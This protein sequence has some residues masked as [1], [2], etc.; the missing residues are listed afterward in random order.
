MR[1]SD[2]PI[3]V[4]DSGIGGLSVLKEA[5]NILTDEKFIYFGDTARI[6]YGIRT[7]EEIEKFTEESFEFLK[8]QGVK[9]GIIA[10]NT[11]TCY[12][13]ETVSKRFDFPIIGVVT[14]SCEAV[15]KITE[16]KNVALLATQGT[17]NSKVYDEHFFDIDPF[18]DLRSVGCP[19]LVVAIENGH[20][21]D[22][23][24]EKIIE[25]YLN[26]I[27]E[28]DY[29]TLILGCTHFPHA[30]KAIERVLNKSNRKVNL[31]DP[32]RTTALDLKAIL[33]K[34]GLLKGNCLES[35]NDSKIVFYTTA[36]IEKFKKTAIEIVGQMIEESN[37]EE[38]SLEE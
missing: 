15:H 24:V 2:R 35:E 36:N 16:N 37:F 6:P 14:P 13:L 5:I 9:A 32:A 19:D 4:F 1:D 22:E 23:Y 21:D 30:R 27:N 34:E 38:I 33:E 28:F 25:K 7:P 20:I 8:K 12:G 11:A 18:V 26:E 17:V 10:C 31:V 29:D 3:G